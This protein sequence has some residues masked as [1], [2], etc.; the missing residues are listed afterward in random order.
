MPHKNNEFRFNAKA[1]VVRVIDGDTF[2]AL[3]QPWPD[4]ERRIEIRLPKV[5]THETYGVSHD[6][7]AYKKGKREED[8]V[9]SWLSRAR[10]HANKKG[11]E[12]PFIVKGEAK[13]SRG[14]YKRWLVDLHRR[15][16][17]EGDTPDELNEALL[18]E[19]GDEIKYDGG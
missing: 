8:Y 2:E 18:G 13:E 12:H 6:S 4:T 11:L 1:K 16:G 9:R 19:F 14:S 10:E 7:K 3:V 17:G 15:G 5:D